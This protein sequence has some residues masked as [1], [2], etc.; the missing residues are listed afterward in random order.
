MRGPE[1]AAPADA[2]VRRGVSHH[3][4]QGIESP[5]LGW[6]PEHTAAQVLFPGGPRALGHEGW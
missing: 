4:Q 1:Q 6:E 2:D 5:H 3:H